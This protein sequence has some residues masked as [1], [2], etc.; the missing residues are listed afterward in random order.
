M[1]VLVG[2]HCTSAT[3][4]SGRPRA[5]RQR[6]PWAMLVL[7]AAFAAD[8]TGRGSITY[9]FTGDCP[10]SCGGVSGTIMFADR[11]LIPGDAERHRLNYAGRPR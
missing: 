10:V 9:T 11:S 4:R 3:G 6:L 5:S 1:S 8:G 2:D 7:V